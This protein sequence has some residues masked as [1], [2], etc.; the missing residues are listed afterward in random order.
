[1]E[2]R[3]EGGR[4][5]AFGGGTA[6]GGYPFSPKGKMDGV[7][8]VLIVPAPG[9]S[10]RARKAGLQGLWLTPSCGSDFTPARSIF[11]R[12]TEKRSAF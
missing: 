10:L 2:G 3:R 8:L 4:F 1:M 5:D 9:Q 12:K 11:F 6:Y 7:L